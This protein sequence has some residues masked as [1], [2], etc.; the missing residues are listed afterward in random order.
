MQHRS[1]YI[2]QLQKQLLKLIAVEQFLN[3]VLLYLEWHIL[4]QLCWQ[5]SCLD[6]GCKVLQHCCITTS[7]D[8]ATW[9]ALPTVTRLSAA[10]LWKPNIHTNIPQHSMHESSQHGVLFLCT[11]ACSWHGRMRKLLWH[12]AMPMQSCKQQHSEWHCNQVQACCCCT[13]SRFSAWFDH[14]LINHM[15]LN[16]T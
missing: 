7:K 12:G 15:M 5:P 16:M 4:Q 8:S 13:Q 3:W 6:N 14:R 11:C 2:Q 1:A 10:D 9:H